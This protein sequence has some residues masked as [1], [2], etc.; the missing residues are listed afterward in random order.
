MPRMRITQPFQSKL[1]TSTEEQ[2]FIAHRLFRAGEVHVV[3]ERF[4]ENGHVLAEFLELGG[5]A[6]VP[7][8]CW[9]EDDRGRFVDFSLN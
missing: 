9:K 7:P 1:Y 2:D 8:E 5:Y 4:K 6:E 3:G